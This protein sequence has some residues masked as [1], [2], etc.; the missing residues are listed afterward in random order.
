M[1][2]LSVS[3][4]GLYVTKA[5]EGAKLIERKSFID[6]VLSSIQSFV[7]AEHNCISELI[8]ETLNAFLMK[9]KEDTNPM[10]LKV[11]EFV[12]LQV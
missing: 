6:T 10:K 1:A 7:L 2:D 5:D 8:A 9:S 4:V 12:S 11:N 3:I